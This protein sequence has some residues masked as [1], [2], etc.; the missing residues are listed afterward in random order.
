M[1]NALLSPEAAALLSIGTPLRK[2][3]SFSRDFSLRFS[4]IVETN[5]SKFTQELG[6]INI[7]VDKEMAK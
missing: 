1:P 7:A 4:R 5:I 3:T 2:I 6:K